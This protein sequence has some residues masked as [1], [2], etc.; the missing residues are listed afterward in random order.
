MASGARPEVYEQR[1]WRGTE[2]FR[3]PLVSFAYER[4]WRQGF[5][6]AGF[7]GGWPSGWGR[8]WGRG[9]VGYARTGARKAHLNLLARHLLCHSSVM[10]Q[11]GMSYR[12]HTARP[13]SPTHQ[14]PHPHTKEKDGGD[15]QQ[16]PPAPNRSGVDREFELAMEYLLP[17]QGG[18]VVDMSCGSG[19]FSRRFAASGRFAGVVAAD[20]SESMLGQ[21]RQYFTEDASLDPR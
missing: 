11:L 13:T 14:H 9:R 15:H 4:G 12:T 19:L 17:A 18:V 6:W 5:A 8:E 21:A 10:Y 7:P 20:F 2:M 3:S 1:A 16:T